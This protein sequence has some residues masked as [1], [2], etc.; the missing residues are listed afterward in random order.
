MSDL[1]ALWNP[2]ELGSTTVANRIVVCAHETYFTHGGPLNEQYVRY[3]QERA[4]AA[5]AW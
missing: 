4:R 1:E 3:L 2:I 5:P